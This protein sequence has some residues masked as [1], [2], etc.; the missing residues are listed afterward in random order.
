MYLRSTRNSRNEVYLQEP[1]GTD[2]EGNELTL[3]ELLAS[4]GGEIGD[5]LEAQEDRLL[6]FSKLDILGELEREVVARRYGLSGLERQ[7]QREIAKSM[8]ISRSYVS[9]I[10]KRAIKKLAKEMSR[11]E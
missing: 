2:K 3:L 7:T 9:R 11:Y 4:D 10:E 6:L 5:D 1:V 8:G